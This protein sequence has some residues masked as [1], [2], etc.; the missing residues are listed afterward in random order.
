MQFLKFPFV[1]SCPEFYDSLS[2]HLP[3]NPPREPATAT[4]PSINA[5]NINKGFI[6]ETASFEG[7]ESVPALTNRLRS[8][9]KLLLENRTVPSKVSFVFVCLNDQYRSMNSFVLPFQP[10]QA[11]QACESEHGQVHSKHVRS[12]WVLLY[13]P[14]LHEP[15]RVYKG[16]YIGFIGFVGFR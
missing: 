15:F 6:E 2:D 10:L 1:F 8:L 4:A 13:L 9:K 16:L 7:D 5:K 3:R 11:S 14:P 12:K